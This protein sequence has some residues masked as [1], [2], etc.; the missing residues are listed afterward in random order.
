MRNL[1]FAVNRGAAAPYRSRL[2]YSRMNTPALPRSFTAFHPTPCNL[3][4]VLSYSTL[5][6][7]QVPVDATYSEA[8]V[9]IVSSRGCEWQLILP[10]IWDT[11]GFGT[12]L[13]R[14]CHKISIASC[15]SFR[16]PSALRQRL[17]SP[18]MRPLP[19]LEGERK[20]GVICNAYF[21]PCPKSAAA[22][23]GRGARCDALAGQRVLSGLA[24]SEGRETRARFRLP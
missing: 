14:A 5:L 13:L 3:C 15:L 1:R 2:G 8:A 12:A 9:A 18:A 24:T 19:R 17:H 6:R 11:F 22:R 16:P 23:T 20:S 7:M 21:V 10:A 4:L